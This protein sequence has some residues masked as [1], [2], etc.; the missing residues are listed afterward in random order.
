MRIE[1]ENLGKRFSSQWIFKDINIDFQ[2]NKSYAITGPNGSG[3]STF[4][5]IISGIAPLSKGKI[6]YLKDGNLVDIEDLYQNIYFCAPYQ[7]LPEELTLSELVD[8]HTK[9]RHFRNNISTQDFLGHI[10]LFKNKDKQIKFFSSGMKQRVKLG[11]ALYSQASLIVLDEPTTNLDQVGIEWYRSE[12][13]NLLS[14]NLIL[15]GSNQMYEYD[16]CDHVFNILK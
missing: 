2:P 3:K 5:Q 9:F 15:I 12:I 13:S 10:G 4:L 8:F 1:V 6:S 11:L 7:E 16:F 14:D